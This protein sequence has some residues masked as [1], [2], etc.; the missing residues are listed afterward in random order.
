MNIDEKAQEYILELETI[1]D[2][3]TAEVEEVREEN[4]I[5]KA[6][7]RAIQNGQKVDYCVA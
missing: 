2:L 4:K 7:I 3:L 6:Q 5:L 1:N